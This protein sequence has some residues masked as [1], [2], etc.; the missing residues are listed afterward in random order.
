VGTAT[1]V[2]AGAVAASA[3]GEGVV[4]AKAVVGRASVEM[5]MEAMVPQMAGAEAGKDGQ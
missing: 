2:V 1:V 3:V 5:E 4:T